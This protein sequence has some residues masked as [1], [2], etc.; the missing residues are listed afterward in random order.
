MGADLYSAGLLVQH[1]V[2]GSGAVSHRE[3]K[4]KKARIKSPKMGNSIEPVAEPEAEEKK[5]A[6]DYKSNHHFHHHHTES[7]IKLMNEIGT[8]YTYKRPIVWFNTIGFL[9]LHMCGIYGVYLM[10]SG[11]AKFWT[12]IYC[13]RVIEYN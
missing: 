2:S 6:K 8:D 3:D 13:E 4:V 10:L 9:V 1:E 7:S 12:S 5:A 11:H